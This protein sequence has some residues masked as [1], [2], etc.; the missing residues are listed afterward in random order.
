MSL[1]TEHLP[2]LRFDIAEAARILQLSR[3]TLYERVREG[4][5]SPSRKQKGE[6]GCELGRSIR[7][8]IFTNG[9]A[10]SVNAMRKHGSIQDKPLMHPQAV[11]GKRDALG[12]CTDR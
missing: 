3:A 5:I 11:I 6:Q 2:Q 12:D 8:S 7:D 9:S 4:R 1:P 10:K